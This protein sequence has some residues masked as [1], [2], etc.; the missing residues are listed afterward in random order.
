MILNLKNICKRYDKEILKN[1]SYTFEPGKLYVIKGVSGCGKTSLLNIL[2]GLDSAF[3]GVRQC[4]AEQ[5]SYIF[6]KSLLLSGLTIRENLTLIRNDEE[7]IGQITEQLGIRSLLER[8]P[9]QLS[10]GE[11][12]RVS[13]ARSL[14]NNPQ[15]LLADEPTASLDG[16]NSRQI[17]KLLASLKSRDRIVIVA[18]HENCF[19]DLADLILHLNYGELQGCPECTELTGRFFSQCMEDN[20]DLKLSSNRETPQKRKPFLRLA[21]KRHSER[22]HFRSLLPLALAFLLLLAAGALEKNYSREARRY[23]AQKY[24][25]DIILLGRDKI[26]K[27]PFRDELKIYDY[28]T[29]AENGLTAYYLLPEKDSVLHV[30]GMLK[31][32]AFPQRPQDV[33]VTQAGA[34]LLFPD[35]DPADC[36]GREFSFKGRTWTICA[37]TNDQ[38]RSF[39]ECFETDIYYHFAADAAVF[40]DYDI[41]H[42]LTEPSLPFWDSY[43][44]VCVLDG[45]GLDPAKQTAAEEAKIFRIELPK[46][47]VEEQRDLINR[48]YQLIDFEQREINESLHRFYL[49]FALLCIL[50]SLYMVSVIRTELFYRKKE[51]GYLQIFGLSKGETGRMLIEEYTI[52]A[53]AGLLLG[54]AVFG[55]ILL[56]YRAFL[57]TWVWTN[58]LSLGLCVLFVGVY[59]ACASITTCL[60]LKKSVLSLIS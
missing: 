20:T 48:F 38:N 39:Q 22:F 56:V 42:E 58:S 50:L 11:R 19:D 41:L 9:S 49:I 29:T 21:V 40:I 28:L 33:I 55:V 26:E 27:F 45:L 24:P 3:D 36:V 32:G 10:G 1:I 15:L 37:V 52:K 17:A 8:L 6:Q 31:A 60:F 54:F 47:Y 35:V 23:A 59:L 34:A 51:L 12:Q 53:V 16:E 2:G 4:D 30:D 7:K 57:G 14:L 44:V 18:T 13:I 46:G 43:N 25:M 5:I